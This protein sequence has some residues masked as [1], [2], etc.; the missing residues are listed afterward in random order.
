MRAVS[1]LV[2]KAGT[3]YSVVVALSMSGCAGDWNVTTRDAGA[4][5]ETSGASGAGDMNDA[6]TPEPEPDALYEEEL[7]QDTGVADGEEPA[8]VEAPADGEPDPVDAGEDAEVPQRAAALASVDTPCSTA[9]E[10]ACTGRNSTQ[11]LVCLAGQWTFDGSCDGATR[12]DA[13]FGTTQGTCQPITSLCLGKRPDEPVCDGTVRHRCGADLLD[14]LPD[15][16]PENSHCQAAET[17][18]CV[19]DSGFTRDGEGGACVDIVDCPAG[20]CVPG[21]ECVDR[22]NAYECKCGPG[23]QANGA[24]CTDI[25]DCMPG[26]CGPGGTCN[27]LVGGYDCSCAAGYAQTANKRGCI[28]VCTTDACY[29]GTCIDG[30]DGYTCDCPLPYCSLA[31]ATGTPQWCECYYPEPDPCGPF[32]CN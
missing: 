28:T 18:E 27:E 15:A 7:E 30:P 26:I 31:G 24:A 6:E 22:T 9:L 1:V 3:R 11:K 2:R 29:P 5:Q 25:V 8:D 14:T 21:G 17:A 20:A 32:A 4:G 13:R 10:S 19:C 16:C 23:Y 12:C